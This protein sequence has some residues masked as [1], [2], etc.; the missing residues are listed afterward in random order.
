MRMTTELYSRIYCITQYTP[1]VGDASIT[2]ML[3][4]A[5][6]ATSSKKRSNCITRT[7]T[8]LPA[9]PSHHACF[10]DLPLTDEE[11]DIKAARTDNLGGHGPIL[12][13]L[14]SSRTGENVGGNYPSTIEPT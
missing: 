11:K 7:N 13:S 8:P 14:S 4:A 3:P 2:V 9:F 5:P 6:V 10:K 12:L 1:A